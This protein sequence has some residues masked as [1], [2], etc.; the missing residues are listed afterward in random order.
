MQPKHKRAFDV[1]RRRVHSAFCAGITLCVTSASLAGGIRPLFE[2]TDLEL[3][4]PGVVDFD[5]Q[6]GIIRG[7]DPWRV[8]IPDF[9]FDLGVARNVELDLDGTYAIQGTSHSPFTSP[10]AVPDALWTS[11]KLGL[12]D[13]YDHDVE[14]AWAVGLQLGPKI[15]VARGN[16]GLGAEGL[17]LLGI[18]VGKTHFVLNSGMLADPY[19][20]A[21]TRRPVGIEL[22]LDIQRSLDNQDRYAF[23]GEISAVRYLS[24][25]PHQLLTTAGLQVSPTK[26]LDLS[27]VALA[28]WLGG[29]DRYGLLLGVSPKI[30][31]FGSN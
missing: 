10:A 5:F 16:H 9:E 28:G 4:D 12:L 7:Q 21:N 2:P 30:R 6:L 18:A 27:I 11:V 3:E 1:V 24:D 22:G 31:I 23:I 20:S 19:P 17:F 26:Y 15:P 8:V 29:S 14:R 13:W 25:Y